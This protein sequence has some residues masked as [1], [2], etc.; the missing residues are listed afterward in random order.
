METNIILTI[1][2]VIIAVIPVV[3]LPRIR[4]AREIALQRNISIDSSMLKLNDFL[5]VDNNYI[6]C[7]RYFIEGSIILYMFRTIVFLA[8]LTIIL[9]VLQEFF[10]LLE[11]D[12]VSKFIN[13]SI[14]LIVFCFLAANVLAKEK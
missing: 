1:A 6:N 11:K 3:S 2:A 8:F 5:K 4:N 7:R 10:G 14:L 12:L 13:G 9:T